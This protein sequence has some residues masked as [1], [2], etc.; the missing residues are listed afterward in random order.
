LNGTITLSDLEGHFCCLKP[1][2]LTYFGEI[3]RVLSTI[4][5][6]MNRNVHVAC[7]VN[8]LFEN[9]ELLKATAS[10]VHCKSC[11]ISERCQIELLL[12]Q[13]T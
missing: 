11:N 3:Q 1:F 13:T 5:S 8:Y 10:H 2:Y 12:L 7:N 6:H 9:E 4:C